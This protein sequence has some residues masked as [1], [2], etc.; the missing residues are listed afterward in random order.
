MCIRDSK[1][2]AAATQNQALAAILFLYRKVL[3]V[4]LPYFEDC[5]RLL[6]A[7]AL[8][9]QAPQQLEIPLPAPSHKVARRG[10]VIVVANR[11]YPGSK[12]WQG[13]HVHRIFSRLVAVQGHI[14]VPDLFIS[15]PQPFPA[16]PPAPTS[17]RFEV[18]R[19]TAAPI[20]T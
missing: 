7:P 12:T 9:S 5:K 1:H 16:D 2:V 6:P 8:P 10:G 17:R 19:H 13:Q 15:K 18:H 3:T 14:V 11:W 20:A 4:E